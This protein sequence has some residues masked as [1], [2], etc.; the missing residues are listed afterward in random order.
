[1][2]IKIFRR[3]GSVIEV[4]KDSE[5]LGYYM[6]QDRKYNIHY[7]LKLA[8]AIV[9]KTAKYS[10]HRLFRLNKYHGD[11]FSFT[12]VDC[13]ETFTTT[14]YDE[15]DKVNPKKVDAYYTIR[16][17]NKTDMLSEP[18]YLKKYDKKDISYG[19]SLNIEKAIMTGE[20][21]AW[22]TAQHLS[23]KYGDDYD[24]YLE[25]LFVKKDRGISIIDD[26]R[27]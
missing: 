25:R 22:I 16:I 6:V 19:S 11:E 9:A 21:K 27:F 7:S 4:H 5:F 24:F 23:W 12:N 14:Y 10:E 8:D 18:G 2:E 13:M 3:Y 15:Y 17:K 20:H 1:M 26:D